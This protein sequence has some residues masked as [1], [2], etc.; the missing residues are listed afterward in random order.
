[1][2]KLYLSKKSTLSLYSPQSRTACPPPYDTGTL[3]IH[4]MDRTKSFQCSFHFLFVMI[5]ACCFPCCN[6]LTTSAPTATP[7]INKTKE[8]YIDT[9][10]VVFINKTVLTHESVELV[11]KVEPRNAT[12][13][14]KWMKGQENLTENERIKSERNKITINRTVANDTGY[15]TCIVKTPLG[16]KRKTAHLTVEEEDDDEE[17]GED[18]D[19]SGRGDHEVSPVTEPPCGRP[20]RKE[21][22]TCKTLEGFPNC[23]SI[24]PDVD[25]ND[26]A[27]IQE[28]SK[29]K[30]FLRIR[31]EWKVPRA[32]NSDIWGWQVMVSDL[33]RRPGVTECR[34]INKMHDKELKNGDFFVEETFHKIDYKSKIEVE[35][36]SLPYRGREKGVTKIV[37][38]IQNA[39][40]CHFFPERPCCYV[41]KNITVEQRGSTSA[42]LSWP[43][44]KNSSLASRL[45]LLGFAVRYNATKRNDDY[46]QKGVFET[47][48]SDAF[49]KT[50]IM[51]DGLQPFCQN[52][53]FKV[54]PIFHSNFCRSCS[55]DCDRNS[56]EGIYSNSY[57]YQMIIIEPPEKAA[58]NKQRLTN[59]HKAIVVVMTVLAVSVI[60]LTVLVAWRRR[61]AFEKGKETETI[62]LGPVTEVFIAH[63]SHCKDCDDAVLSV[64]TYLNMTGHCKCSLDLCS[65]PKEWSPGMTQYYENQISKC[66]KVI[67]LFT[68]NKNHE[69]EDT[70]KAR[71]YTYQENLI[72]SEL[73][74]NCPTTKFIPVYMDFLSDLD[75]PS[76]LRNRKSFSLPSQLTELVLYIIGEPV[77]K[78]VSD[79]PMQALEEDSSLLKHKKILE[80]KIKDLNAKHH[81]KLRNKNNNM[82]EK[83]V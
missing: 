60:C 31:V 74:T 54:A 11:C 10:E 41:I 3:K 37:S 4:A 16:F 25:I 45:K 63:A 76:F 24:A 42:A 67:V 32:G 15:Y 80:T 22:T 35:I 53:S 64:A 12:L 47:R 21:R 39:N 57:H 2:H 20:Q 19:F 58:S 70:I 59:V 36:R 40:D 66:P 5:T 62:P 78:P 6:T 52:Y 9:V 50:H 61:R 7:K 73:L 69:C 55:F 43:D 26:I 44:L 51:V 8:I 71:N 82:L 14:I 17:E 77:C 65:L 30:H 75:I 83:I 49:N 13:T 81:K 27:I 28:Q 68:V 23:K 72:R 79:C 46:C 18:D 48:A 56:G 33:L 1:M 29:H 38:T 34:Q